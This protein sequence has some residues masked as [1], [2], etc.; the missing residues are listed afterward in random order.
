MTTVLQTAVCL[1]VDGHSSHI[2]LE[3]SQFCKSNGI[4]LYCLPPHSSHI[5]QPLD[6]G[7]FS[8]LKQSWKNAVAEFNLEHPGSSVDKSTFA[9]VFKHAYLSS[10]KSKTIVHAF[11]ASGIYPP[12]R[13][14]IDECKLQPA[15][16]FNTS[17]P[18]QPEQNQGKNLAL[19]ALE[20]AIDKELL[21]YEVR[22]QEGYDMK[23]D[24][25]YNTWKKLSR[26]A[27]LSDI[28]NKILMPIQPEIIQIP[29]ATMKKTV[30]TIQGTAC[31]PKHLSGP[32]MMHFWR[33]GR[34][35][36]KE[37]KRRKK[38]INNKEKNVR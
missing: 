1:L 32:E 13:Y 37:K 29:T 8:P 26:H 11:K 5:T 24:L 20:E 34:Q 12:N 21:K 31:M 7:F 2:S 22:L 4:L 9:G 30:K 6:V 10:I 17:E 36:R 33:S 18:A 23:D 28:T 14:A 19:A 35:K 3:A 27:P 15:K 25:V 38:N 16:V